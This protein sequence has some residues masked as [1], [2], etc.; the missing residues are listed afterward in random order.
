MK[1]ATRRFTFLVV[2]AVGYATVASANGPAVTAKVNSVGTYDDGS[3]YIYFDRAISAC[4][5]TNRL[6]VSASIVA[7]K[8][9]LAL[10]TTAFV[11]GSSVVVHPGGCTGAYPT[12]T[13]DGDSFIYLTR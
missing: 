11:S 7:A 10:A 1:A 4:S 9:V 3:I 2:V 6:D 8:N 12:F 5:T 13:S